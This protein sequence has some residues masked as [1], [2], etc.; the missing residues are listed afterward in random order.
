MSRTC[1]NVARRSGEAAGWIVPGVILA[2]VP[3]CPMCV[4]AY[5]ALATGVSITMSAASMVRTSM[6][7]VSFAALMYFAGRRLLRFVKA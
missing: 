6:I 2:L 7:V 5:V 1:C 3:K 4:A